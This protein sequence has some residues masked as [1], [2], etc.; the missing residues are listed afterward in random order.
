MSVL[1]L[2]RSDLRSFAGYSSARTESL[3]GDIWL[4]A[5]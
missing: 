4:N 5:N 3:Q 1:D 2:V